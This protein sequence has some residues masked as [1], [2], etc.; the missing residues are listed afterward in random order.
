ML[1]GLIHDLKNLITVDIHPILE[2]TYPLEY[3]DH[4]YDSFVIQDKPHNDP[5]ELY[6]KPMIEALAKELNRFDYLI[7]AKF[8]GRPRGSWVRQ[9]QKELDNIVIRKTMSYTLGESTSC[10]D[11]YDFDECREKNC[12]FKSKLLYGSGTRY[13]FDMLLIKNE[14]LG[15]I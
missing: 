4:L 10:P 5:L 2:G 13:N 15:F 8:D 3:Y 7:F 6:T 14:M 11:H 9:T 12:T 1:D